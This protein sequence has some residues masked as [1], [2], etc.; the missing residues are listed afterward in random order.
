MKQL[1]ATKNT[2]QGLASVLMRFVG[3]YIFI[4]VKEK[5]PESMNLINQYRQKGVKIEE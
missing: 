5:S 1:R 4:R 3:K 2:P